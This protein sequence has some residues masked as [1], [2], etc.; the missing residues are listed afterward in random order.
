VHSVEGRVAH[1]T[2]VDST[3]QFLLLAQLR[4]IRDAGGEPL[5][6]SRAG[7][8]V[9][10]LRAEGIRHRA[11]V[12]STRSPNLIADLRAACELW[13]VLRNERPQILHTHN[14]KPGVYGRI[15]GWLAGVPIIVNTVHGLYATERDPLLRRAAVYLLEALASRFS[16][17]ELVQNPED[18]ALMERFRIVRPG[19]AYLLGNGVDLHRFD[20]SRVPDAERAAV[21]A[22]LGAGEDTIVVGTVGRLVAEKGY[23]ELVAAAEAL[24]SR[25]VFVAAGPEDPAK[26]DRLGDALMARASG[27]GVRLLGFR[28]DVER[29]YRAMDLFVLPSHR[30][31]FPRAAMEAAAMGVPVVASAIRGCRQVVE[32][33][34]TGILVPVGDV[35]GLVAAIRTLGENR[36]LRLG[37]GRA[38][39]E[40]AVARFDERAVVAR[41]LTAYRELAR[42]RATARRQS[43]R[44]AGPRIHSGP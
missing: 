1:L 11:L 9:A 20:P 2:T 17:A 19:R 18:L 44:T 4:A 37:M 10:N 38:A 22:S 36:E 30:E 14:P 42:R 26:P 34:R 13:R 23:G 28:P 15:V 21:R 43:D 16:D 5:G 6:I 25:Y 3:L 35:A 32:P 24:D 33:G 31:G 39:R 41:V 12:S 8:W 40:R 7:P 29:L 27:A